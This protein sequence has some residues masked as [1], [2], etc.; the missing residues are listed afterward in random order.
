M[1]RWARGVDELGCEGLH[2][3]IDR[4]VVNDDAAFGQQLLDVAVGESITQIPAHRDRDDLTRE[5]VA[6]RR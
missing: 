5:P 1:P 6:G 2:P 3:P 4:D